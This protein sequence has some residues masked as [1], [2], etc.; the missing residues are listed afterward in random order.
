LTELEAILDRLERIEVLLSAQTRRWLSIDEAADYAGLS[1]KTVRRMIR[2]GQLS[3]H[4]PAR[5][6]ILIDREELDAVIR[7]SK[8]AIRGGRGMCRTTASK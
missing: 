8:G 3:A 1:S 5:G 6:K 4:R 2:A 7:Q